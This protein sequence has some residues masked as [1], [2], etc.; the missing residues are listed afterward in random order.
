MRE[1]KSISF[2]TDGALTK[3]IS[4]HSTMHA[5]LT[6][7]MEKKTSATS[8]TTILRRPIPSKIRAYAKLFIHNK[9]P[10]IRH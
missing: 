7:K 4:E 6:A 1:L 2:Y 10:T 3:I 8:S 5:L 9:Q